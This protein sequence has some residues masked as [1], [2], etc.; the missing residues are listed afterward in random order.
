MTV[1]PPISLAGASLLKSRRER[2]VQAL[3]FEALAIGVC[4]PLFAWVMGTS[5]FDMGAFTAATCVIALVWNVV[6]N[7]RFD[8]LLHRRGWRKGLLARCM[9][10]VLF[11]AGLL[12]A[13]VPL[14][15]WWLQISLWAAF[16][17]DVGL[18]AFFLPYTWVFHW[19]WDH[20][21]ERRL[22]RAG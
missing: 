6:F 14:A 4:T 15:A 20:L 5:L 11:E 1:S 19:T 8:R 17:L 12:L 22:Q 2:V 18:I 10:A 7:T 9:H 3:V 21:R 13:T 16:W